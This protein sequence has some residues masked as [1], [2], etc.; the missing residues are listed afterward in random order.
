MVESA[1]GKYT[2]SMPENQTIKVGETTTIKATVMNGDT[3]VLDADGVI[4]QN[5]NSSAVKMDEISGYYEVMVEVKGLKAGTSTITAKYKNIKAS[6]TVTVTD[7]REPVFD[8]TRDGW[9]F[10][11]AAI[12]FKYG[13]FD[14]GVYA[15]PI[16]RYIEVYGEKIQPFARDFVGNWGGN[17]Y[18]MCALAYKIFNGEIKW[19]RN[20]EVNE[21]GYDVINTN[22]STLFSGAEKLPSLTPD[23]ELCKQIERYQIAQSSIDNNRTNYEANTYHE[24]F[25]N[26]ESKLK[27]GNTISLAVHWQE[28]GKHVGHQ[29]LVDTS[30]EIEKDG[31]WH[32]LYLYDPNNPHY[33]NN[34][35]LNLPN[36]YEHW[37][38]RYIDYNIRTGEWYLEVGVSS[39]S[40]ST[41][42]HK[43]ANS[44]FSTD[45]VWLRFEDFN[46]LPNSFDN[47]TL[48]FC[49]R[50][51]VYL[52][53]YNVKINN[54]FGDTI[55]YM[56]NG[57]IV[58]SKC[59][60]ISIS[61]DEFTNEGTGVNGYIDLKQNEYNIE[62]SEGMVAATGDDNITA[63]KSDGKVLIDINNNDCTDILTALDDSNVTVL[64]EKIE[65][66]EYSSK[67]VYGILNKDEDITMNYSKKP[68]IST[69]SKNKFNVLEMSNFNEKEYTNI[70]LNNYAE[71]GNSDNEFTSFNSP[72]SGWAKEEVE[73]AYKEDLI[74]NV[75]I[76]DDLT[77]KIDRSE[78]AAIAVKMYEKLSDTTVSAGSNPFKDIDGNASK[79]DI[80]KAYKLGI[81]AGVSDSSFEPNTLINR[82][83]L[84]TMLCRAIKKYS[85]DGWSLDRD[86][87]YYLDTSGV[88]K[89]ADDADISEFAK[90]S[91]YYMTKFGIIKGIDDTHFAPKNT[92][93]AQEAIGY[94]M[95]T[96]EQAIALSLRIFKMSDVW[97]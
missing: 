79:S 90:P 89:F 93:S 18:G 41:Q 95:A 60:Y 72:V 94:A 62:F 23:S 76:G 70:S 46:S 74:P 85:F 87:E 8:I 88:P 35:K 28:Q 78:F 48:S 44:T 75:L 92:T 49:A 86:S 32:R 2:I 96:K 17:C 12:G 81:T 42:L 39:D 27:N 26:V 34:E 7:D 9:P 5:S 11:N 47:T 80:L 19:N 84:A 56:I 97:K 25:E 4:W 54:A 50:G 43:E 13:L 38:N 30:R 6:C 58:E 36:C 16:D 10:P 61:E 55:F 77:Q 1:S 52:G 21:K 63:V 57:D 69:T 20:G 53:S 24:M 51:R 73:E 3:M 40:G 66:D 82:E 83:Q 64:N 14:L 29:L 65:G 37:N 67:T 22:D 15:I 33:D 68:E 45:N 31:E 71:A 59:D 91:V